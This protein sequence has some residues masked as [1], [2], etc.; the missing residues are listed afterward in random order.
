MRLRYNFYRFAIGNYCAIGYDVRIVTTNHH[1][2]YAN[3]Q[4]ALQRNYG[5]KDLEVSGK[6]VKVGNNVW[7]GD[8]VSILSGVTIGDGAV[9]AAGC[10]VTKD[11]GPYSIVAGVPATHLKYRFNENTRNELEEVSWWYWSKDKI[12]RNPRFFETDFSD[13]NGSIFELIIN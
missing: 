10:V 1:T 5:F 13:F 2:G 4:L 9:L 8:G 3:L 6:A 7:V 12:A 11:V